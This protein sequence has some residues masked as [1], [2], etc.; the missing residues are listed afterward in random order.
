MEAGQNNSFI[1]IKGKSIGN[2]CSYTVSVR[3]NDDDA[4]NDMTKDADGIIFVESRAT[5]SDGS[6]AGIEVG[7]SGLLSSGTATGYAA[8][9]GAGSGKSYRAD[10]VDSI[11]DFTLQTAITP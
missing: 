5:T 2:A 4:S 1:W 9:A 10:D 3:D 8:Q 7:L 6:T 11:T